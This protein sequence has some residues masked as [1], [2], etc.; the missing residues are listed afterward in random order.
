LWSRHLTGCLCVL[1]LL[2]SS[3]AFSANQRPAK[4]E[5]DKAIGPCIGAV[6]LG[7]ILGGI[8]AGSHR[9]YDPQ[10]GQTRS[11]RNTGR[12]V[13]L[14]A[15]AGGVVCA[16][17]MISARHKD[18][19]I[20]AQREAARTGQQYVASYRDSNGTI[21]TVVATPEVVTPTKPLKQVKY[22]DETGAQSVSP[23]LTDAPTLCR[24]VPVTISDGTN[25]TR[26]SGQ[27][28]CMN[29]TTNRMEPYSESGSIA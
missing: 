2:S 24:R 6:V 14:G 22:T 20:T 27:L 9:E 7:A 26:I 23:L 4:S 13:A 19:I 25:S 8:L 28:M 1:G 21:Q 3:A 11:V 16:I 10:T 5:V 18:K 12:G 15:G 17:L 29:S